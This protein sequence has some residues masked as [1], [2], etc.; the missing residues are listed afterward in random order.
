MIN[1][2]HADHP[3]RPK[4][5]S[6]RPSDCCRVLETARFVQKALGRI[7]ITCQDAL[8]VFDYRGGHGHVSADVNQRM[9]FGVTLPPSSPSVVSMAGSGR[10]SGGLRDLEIGSDPPLP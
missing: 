4:Q 10:R 7:D 8:H 1:M 5:A 9:P 3:D 2:V 6:H